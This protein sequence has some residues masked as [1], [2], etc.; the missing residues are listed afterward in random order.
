M[1]NAVLILLPVG[2]G[3][4]LGIWLGLPCLRRCFPGRRLVLMQ[5]IVFFGLTSVLLFRNN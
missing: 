4:C 5:A 2:A 3:V 1:A